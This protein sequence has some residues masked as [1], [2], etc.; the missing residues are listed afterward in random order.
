MYLLH[1]LHLFRHTPSLSIPQSFIPSPEPSVYTHEP[2]SSKHWTPNKV[3][4]LPSI[5][6]R[7]SHLQSPSLIS[8]SIFL[9]LP[10]Y[11]FTLHG[12][13]VPKCFLFPFSYHFHSSPMDFLLNFSKHF[14]SLA[15]IFLH[16]LQFIHF[17]LHPFLIFILPLSNFASIVVFLDCSLEAGSFPRLYIPSPFTAQTFLASPVLNLVLARPVL[18]DACHKEKK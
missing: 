9:P 3:R 4:N 13:A 11:S 10:L 8:H 7:A 5:S 15:S 14:P 16:L 12:L 6:S 18:A 1:C 17:L 2:F